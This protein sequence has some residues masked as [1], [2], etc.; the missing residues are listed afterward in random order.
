MPAVDGSGQ[1]RLVDAL[2][3]AVVEAVG[4]HPRGDP[5]IPEGS[6]RHLLVSPGTA[7]RCT[8]TAVVVADHERNG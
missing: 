5:L 1:G 8:A 7:A 4:R 3:P 2:A 6:G